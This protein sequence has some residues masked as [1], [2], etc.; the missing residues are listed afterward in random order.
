MSLNRARTQAIA[1]SSQKTNDPGNA[2]RNPK[3]VWPPVRHKVRHGEAE[4]PE[5]RHRATDYPADPRAPRLVNEPSSDKASAKAMLMRAP[6]DAARP[7]RKVS[8]LLWVANAAANDSVE[9]DP[10]IRTAGP[11]CTYCSTNIR[12]EV[13]SS[14]LGTSGVTFASV[15]FC[16]SSPSPFST[17]ARSSSRRR[18]PTSVARSAAFS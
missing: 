13:A 17:M 6:T 10:S 16:A 14:A 18:T 15:N 8:Q 4:A 11:A 7:T 2:G 1:Q 9:T 5:R 3:C 12:W